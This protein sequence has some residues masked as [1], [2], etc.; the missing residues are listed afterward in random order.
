MENNSQQVRKFTTMVVSCMIA[1]VAVV[2]VAVASFI[3]LGSAR[4]KSA[5][6]DE[7]I[8][9]LT[10]QEQLLKEN[11]DY[12]DSPMYI[13]EQARNEHGMLK[14]NEKLVIFQK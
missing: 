3:T 6:Y 9:S 12:M 13:E 11:I 8:A 7:M 14:E 2:I 1:F 10:K 5:K 4:R